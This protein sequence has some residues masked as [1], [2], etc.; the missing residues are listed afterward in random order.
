MQIREVVTAFHFE[1][2]VRKLSPKTT[3]LYDH[4]LEYPAGYLKNVAYIPDREEVRSSL[5]VF[6]DT[7]VRLTE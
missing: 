1:G 4:R 7:D 6:F 3:A 2:Q 5:A